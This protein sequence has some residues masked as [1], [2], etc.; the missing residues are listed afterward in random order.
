MSNPRDRGLLISI[1][2]R[3]AEAI[4][5]GVKSIELRRTRPRVLPGTMVLLYASS[6]RMAVIARARVSR[7]VEDEPHRIWHDHEDAVGITAQEF[8]EY[9]EGARIAYGLVLTE[10]TAL[11]PLPIAGLRALG[12]E[13]PQSWR[14]LASDLLDRI[15]CQSAA[16]SDREEAAG[17]GARLK[18]SARATA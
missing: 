9:F 6:P 3:F 18:G 14:Y 17:T 8:V 11:E 5:S 2:P 13:P 12:L 1:R 4:L 15:G 7:I 16:P 10:V